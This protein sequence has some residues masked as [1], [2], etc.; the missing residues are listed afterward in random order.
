M[1]D[2]KISCSIARHEQHRFLNYASISLGIPS[3]TTCKPTIRIRAQI[4]VA[5]TSG[6][7]QARDALAD[8][9]RRLECRDGEGPRWF[10]RAGTGLQ[11]ACLGEWKSGEAQA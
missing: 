6:Q 3:T 11:G 1:G 4:E 8:G 9:E 2:Y 7:V 10:R 5:A